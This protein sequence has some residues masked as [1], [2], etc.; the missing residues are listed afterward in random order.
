MSFVYPTLGDTKSNLIMIKSLQKLRLSLLFGTLTLL[1][2]FNSSCRKDHLNQTSDVPITAVNS[3]IGEKISPK[4]LSK[5]LQIV[6]VEYRPFLQLV[7]AKQKVINNHNIIVIPIAGDAAIF[8]TKEQGEIKGWIYKW[9][10]SKPKEKKF[11]GKLVTYSLQEKKAWLQVYENGALVQQNELTGQGNSLVKVQGNMKVMSVGSFFDK[12]FC[13]MFGGNWVMNP[14]GEVTGEYGCEPPANQQSDNE[15]GDND[16]G[17]SSNY[18]PSLPPGIWYGPNQ[19]TSGDPNGGGYT[20]T[21][22]GGSTNGPSVPPYGGGGIWVTEF[23]NDGG[24]P[25]CMIN[26]QMSDVPD[27][28][29]CPGTVIPSGQFV[30]YF[31]TD[32]DMLTESLGLNQVEHDFLAT[33]TDITQLIN[34]QLQ[35][36]YSAETVDLLKWAVSYLYNNSSVPLETFKNQFLAE[37]EGSDGD[38][39]D[40]AYWD[41]PNL[42]FPTQSLPTY[43]AFAAAYPGHHDARFDSAVEVYTAIGG[44][45]LDI[46]TAHPLENENTCAAR[47]SVA[48]QACGISIPHLPGKTFK[49]KENQYYFMGA[50]NMISW[51]KMT[52][53]IPTGSNHIT[54]AE[55][56]LRS[57]NVSD[58]LSGKKGIY[59]LIPINT[60]K[61]TGFGASGHID[62]LINQKCDGGCYFYPKGG[63]IKDIY[64]WPLQ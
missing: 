38:D 46:Y 3:N 55:A 43:Q 33:R 48:L 36:N 58:L 57:A 31:I 22:G 14:R 16:G 2:T 45:M 60:S 18:D 34:A 10:N 8:V 27:G 12:I 13:W 47:L 15:G 51:M 32:A 40:S 59:G 4:E 39:Y 5:W 25:G 26:G 37:L 9:I 54:A 56:G 29:E 6:P 1:L 11:T 19:V 49:G 42:S 44:A 52:F 41:N 50:A 30:Q 53:G 23:V 21:T 62:M 63:G 20:G 64:I 35:T 61:Q 17:P 7:N 28:E 24:T